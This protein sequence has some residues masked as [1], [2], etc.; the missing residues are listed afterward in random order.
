ME[1]NPRPGLQLLPVLNLISDT[2]D[3]GE[4]VFLP[5]FTDLE[6]ISEAYHVTDSNSRIYKTLSLLVRLGFPNL[7]PIS[8]SFE[9]KKIQAIIL[10][11]SL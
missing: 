9:A 4:E 3:T 2:Y 11:S 1:G 8:L 6:T 7:F 10:R 5:F